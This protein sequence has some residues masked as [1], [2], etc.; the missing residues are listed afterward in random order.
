ME[1]EAFRTHHYD[2]KKN[3]VTHRYEPSLK[4]SLGI[5]RKGTAREATSLAVYS[6]RVRSSRSD[7]RLELP[8]GGGVVLPH[9]SHIGIC[10]LKG[11]GFWSVLVWNRVQILTILL[12]NRVRYVHSDLELGTVVRRSATFEYGTNVFRIFKTKLWPVSIQ[13]IPQYWSPYISYDNFREDVEFQ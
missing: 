5:V 13:I 7:Q 11:Y 8:G 12:W 6:A 4:R 9:K 10:G 2:M 1:F 3:Y